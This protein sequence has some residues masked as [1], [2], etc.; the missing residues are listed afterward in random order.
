MGS[1]PQFRM[2]SSSSGIP[3]PNPG[4]MPQG[5]HVFMDMAP[6]MGLRI[7]FGMQGFNYVFT[8]YAL[9]CKVLCVI[10]FCFVHKVTMIVSNE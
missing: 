1:G 7:P 2:G 6:G 3:F 8:A 9:L 5:M 10:N 4:A